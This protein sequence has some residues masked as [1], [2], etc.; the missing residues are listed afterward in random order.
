MS[1][2]SSLLPSAPTAMDMQQQPMP[3]IATRSTMETSNDNSMDFQGFDQDEE[4]D[5]CLPPTTCVN[6]SEIFKSGSSNDHDFDLLNLERRRSSTKS[7]KG[8]GVETVVISLFIA[9][10]I[11]DLVNTDEDLFDDDT[12]DW[13]NFL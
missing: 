12:I 1:N 6:P 10:P 7:L 9:L 11:S 2:P 8:E 3:P 4:D 13:D 5:D